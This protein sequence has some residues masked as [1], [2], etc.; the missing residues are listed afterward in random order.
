MALE[1]IGGGMIHRSISMFPL[2]DGELVLSPALQGLHI[3]SDFL[4]GVSYVA[5]SLTLLSLIAKA[6]KAIPFHWIVLSF[7]G[8][9]VSCGW[10]HF[11]HVAVV[12]NAGNWYWLI[13]SQVVTVIASVTTAVVLPS[14]VPKVL[15]LVRE[16]QRSEAYKAELI[17]AKDKA[18]AA[19]QAKTDFLAT[20]SHELRSPLTAILG[21]NELLRDDLLTDPAERH[22]AFNDV[23]RSGTHL[24]NLINDVLDMAKVEAGRMELNLAPLDLASDLEGVASILHEQAATRDLALIVAVD[25]LPQVV[26][27]RQKLTQVVIN[28]VSNAVKFTPAGGTVTLSARPDGDHVRIAVADTGI[29][30]SDA[31]QQKLFQPFTQVDSSLSRRHEGTGLG[32]ALTRRLVELHGGTISVQSTLGQGSTFIVS[33]PVHPTQHVYANPSGSQRINDA[34]RLVPAKT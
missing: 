16:A 28:L 19:N 15:S 11:M 7:G 1:A 26:A 18:E 4:I 33:L 20:M 24:L 5:I 22:A 6:G 29:G 27:D 25:P 31:D 30:I 34:A 13:I 23:E 14:V 9:I 17:A 8:F 12:A 2:A 32:L 3:A 10:T 21:F